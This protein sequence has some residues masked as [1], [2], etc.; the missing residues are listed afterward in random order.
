VL[1]RAALRSPRKVEI[2]KLDLAAAVSASFFA[3]LGSAHPE[4]P[5]NWAHDN[6]AAQANRHLQVEFGDRVPVLFVNER[7][8]WSGRVHE[9]AL[10]RA[11]ASP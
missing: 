7:L 10:A 11:L 3:A 4:S 1:R 2:E 8:V 5:T 9:P 6:P